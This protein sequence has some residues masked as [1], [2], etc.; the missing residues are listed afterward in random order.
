MDK[1]YQTFFDKV[2]KQVARF[3]KTLQNIQP[4]T[5]II[6]EKTRLYSIFF[7]GQ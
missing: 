6:N 7:V 1:N 4:K 2:V 3:V 5:F